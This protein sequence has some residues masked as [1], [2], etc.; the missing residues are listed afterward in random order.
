V[1]II[2]FLI[3]CFFL[4]ACAT[5][6]E[7]ITSGVKKETLPLTWR[8]KANGKTEGEVVFKT[9]Y[10]DILQEAPMSVVMSIFGQPYAISSQQQ[11]EVWSYHLKNREKIFVFFQNGR[12]VDVKAR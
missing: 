9:A 3:I 7:R 10:G 12:V 4:T 5:A 8:E 11:S 1:K 2:D 6:P